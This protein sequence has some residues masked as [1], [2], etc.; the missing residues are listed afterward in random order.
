MSRLPMFPLGTTLLPGVP[1]PLHVFEPRYRA[2][3]EECLATTPE[4]GVVLIARGSEVGG[5]DVRHGVGVRARILQAASLG[6]GR[7]ALW[8]VGTE[9]FRVSR[10]LAEEPFPLADVEPWPDDAEPWPDDAENGGSPREYASLVARVRRLAALA[11]ELGDA[12]LDPT[13]ELPTGGELERSPLSYALSALAPLGPADRQRLLECVGPASRLDML[14]GL[15]DEVEPS[16]L[17][18]LGD[19]P[20]PLDSPPAW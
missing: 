18:R 8:C 4:F 3:V 2:L 7:Y 1:L 6:E 15:L 19:G 14:T 9:R 5:G 12:V 17:F 11:S 16:L 10:W 20:S 13:G